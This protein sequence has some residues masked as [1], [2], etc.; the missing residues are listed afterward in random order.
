MNKQNK[1]RRQGAILADG[2]YLFS[3]KYFACSANI[4]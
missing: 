2:E 1:H 4:A 3:E